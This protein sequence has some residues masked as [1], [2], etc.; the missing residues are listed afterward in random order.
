MLLEL[1]YFADLRT[2]QQPSDLIDGLDS[3]YTEFFIA[4]RLASNAIREMGGTYSNIVKQLLQCNFGCGDDL[5]DPKLQV[6]F[7]KDIICE[8]GRLEQAFRELE[9]G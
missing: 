6:M 9:L 3:R 7:Y 8:L 1:A 5:N 4:K 2:L